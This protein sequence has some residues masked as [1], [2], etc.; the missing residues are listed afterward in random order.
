[1]GRKKKNTNYFNEE[2]E[3]AVRDYIRSNDTAFKDKIFREKIYIPLKKICEVY[4]NT[5]QLNYIDR[6]KDDLINECLAHLVINVFAKFN[7]ESNTKAYSYFSVSA[8]YWFMQ[9]NMRGYTHSKRSYEDVEVL[10]DTIDDYH[11]K[12]EF[13]RDLLEKYYSFIAWYRKSLDSLDFSKNMK[14]HIHAILSM[15]E[16]FDEIVI[17][18]K[19][20]VMKAIEER[21]PYY[22]EVTGRHARIQI[23]RQWLYYCKCYDEGDKNP[24]P[25][26]KLNYGPTG[27]LAFNSVVPTRKFKYKKNPR[28]YYIRKSRCKD[29]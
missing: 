8:K 21:F 17:F 28:Y 22:T 6:D 14:M 7:P 10:N 29:C 13:D 26:A 27:G 15:L 5:S 9:E 18:Y 2:T 12:V 24:K 19:R 3:Q 1:M 16:E 23:Y 4:C 25:L 11:N 20:E